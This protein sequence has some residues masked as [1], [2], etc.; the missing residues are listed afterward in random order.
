[1]SDD[2]LVPCGEAEAVQRM[3]ELEASRRGQ[4]AWGTGNYDP[5]HPE[6]FGMT[7]N[8]DLQ[9][10]DC[11]GAAVCHS[12]RLFRHRPGFNRQPHATIEDDINVDSILEDADPERGGRCELGELVTIPAPGILLLTPSIHLEANEHHGK[13]DEPG[14]VR[15][16][17]DA[18]RWNPAAPRW[19]DVIYLEC[20]GPNKHTPGVTRSTGESVDRWDAKWPKPMHRAAMVRVRARPA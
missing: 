11:A 9:G 4:Y 6:L 18:T 8:H 7:T 20:H 10:W 13:F 1:M 3:L 5:K 15:L 12:F 2:G 17:I 19:A 14:H 16:I